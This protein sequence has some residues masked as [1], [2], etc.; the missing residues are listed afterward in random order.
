MGMMQ[1]LL[2]RTNQMI[3]IVALSTVRGTWR[4][5][6]IVSGLG[7]DDEPCLQTQHQRVWGWGSFRPL[8]HPRCLWKELLLW[9]KEMFW[10]ILS[11]SRHVLSPIVLSDL[12]SCRGYYELEM[13]LCS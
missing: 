3:Q 13:E 6:S 8:D 10:M 9:D 4:K 11:K 7:G 1:Y 5:A 12:P 2:Q